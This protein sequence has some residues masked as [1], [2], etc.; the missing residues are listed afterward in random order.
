M[1]KTPRLVIAVVVNKQAMLNDECEK[2]ELFMKVFS[3][4]LARLTS[5]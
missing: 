5:T 2:F 3:M 1:S 4:F